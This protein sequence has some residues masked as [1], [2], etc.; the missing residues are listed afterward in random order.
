M[1]AQEKSFQP[2]SLTAQDAD[3]HCCWEVQL[4]RG[5]AHPHWQWEKVLLTCDL[6]LFQ[7]NGLQRGDVGQGL[8]ETP[9]SVAGE[10]DG[11]E[12]QQGSDVLGQAVQVVACQVE[13]CG[14]SE[15]GGGMGR[16]KDGKIINS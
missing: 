16:R 6:V 14:L 11:L 1:V 13:L 3:W 12:V 7:V 9:K 8:R 2:E 15:R 5:D 4:S 10:V